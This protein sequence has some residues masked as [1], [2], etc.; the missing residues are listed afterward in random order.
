MRL[1]HG[2]QAAADLVGDKPDQNEEAVRG[3]EVRSLTR[4][5]GAWGVGGCAGGYGAMER[6]GN[7]GELGP[8]AV[9][10]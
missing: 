6:C 9:A 4:G 8:L 5:R 1:D 7:P 10:N 2:R 3:R